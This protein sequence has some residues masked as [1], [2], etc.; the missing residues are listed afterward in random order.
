MCAKGEIESRDTC[1][2]SVCMKMQISYD[3]PLVQEPCRPTMR[4]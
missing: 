3:D 1:M 2:Y 4:G